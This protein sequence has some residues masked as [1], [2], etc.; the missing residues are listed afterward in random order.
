MVSSAIYPFNAFQ[1]VPKALL[2]RELRFK[3]LALSETIRSV[4]QI[5][6]TLQ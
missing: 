6:A 3:L 2:Q 5:I 1:V 4:F